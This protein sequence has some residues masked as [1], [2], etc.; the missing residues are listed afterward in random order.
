MLELSWWLWA[1]DLQSIVIFCDSRDRTSAAHARSLPKLLSNTHDYSA[2]FY[3]L[4]LA[5]FRIS[6][7][8]GCILTGVVSTCAY[9]NCVILTRVILIRVIS[10][11][12]ICKIYYNRKMRDTKYPKKT[13]HGRR[14]ISIPISNI[15]NKDWRIII[16]QICSYFFVGY[17]S[18]VVDQ[19]CRL[20]AFKPRN[21]KS[22]TY[23]L[24]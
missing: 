17:A 5:Y 23:K 1:A 21:L 3:M 2:V 12:G 24:I 14:I 11:R 6:L 18:K 22:E 19:A 4:N 7:L 9:S 8:R 10:T 16:M 20:V 15:I 13:T